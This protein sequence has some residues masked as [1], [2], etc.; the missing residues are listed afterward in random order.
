LKLSSIARTIKELPRELLLLGLMVL[1][2]TGV[3]AAET[4]EFVIVDGDTLWVADTVVVLGSRVPVAGPGLVRSTAILDDEAIARLPVRSPAEALAMLPQVTVNQRQQFG[5]QADLSIRGSTFEQVQVLLDGFPVGDPQTGHHNLNLPMSTAD[6]ARLEVLGGQGSSLYGTGAFGGTLNVVS[7]V[8]SR[9]AGAELELGAGDFA[10]RSG[11][12][13]LESG[14]RDVLGHQARGRLGVQYFRSDGDRP[15]TDTDNLNL[16]GRGRLQVGDTPVDVSAGY[17]RREFGARDFYVP[18]PSF[19]RTEAV[20]TSLRLQHDLGSRLSFEPRVHLRRHVD[21]FVLFRDNPPAYTNDHTSLN[22]NGEGRLAYYLSR[23]LTVSS[24]IVGNYQDITSTGVRSGVSAPALGD[25][26]RRRLSAGIELAGSHH[27]FNWNAGSRV[28]RQT[29]LDAEFSHSAALAWHPNADLTLRS[30]IGTVFRAPTFTELYYVDPGNIGDAGLDPERGWAWD[31]G[32]EW[33]RSVWRLGGT[34]FRRHEED[35]IDWISPTDTTLPWQAMNIGEAR[36]QGWSQTIGLHDDAGRN[37]RLHY[38]YL[39]KSLDLPAGLTS[40]YALLSP[41]HLAALSLQL[42]IGGHLS[43]TPV[44][45]YRERP[46]LDGDLLSDI[47][48]RGDWTQWFSRIDLTN[49]TDRDYEE[50]PGVPMP[51]RMISVSVGRRI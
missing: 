27:A 20:F 7:R 34:Y 49:I 44:L 14:A 35:L 39:D 36:V 43:L 15:G 2:V 40:K 22:L 28:D 29:D 11:R 47:S 13:A 45:R 4:P 12:L 31:C 26:L 10:S 9:Q 32:V 46:R 17:A 23:D 16:F 3:A 51:G 38:T 30:S 21:H 5:T 18:F 25:H 6:I 1:A 19:E 50:V 42:P 33:S 37:L 48:L 8:P 24:V 41:R